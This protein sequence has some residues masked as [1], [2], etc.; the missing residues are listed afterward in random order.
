M[1]AKIKQFS[2]LCIPTRLCLCF[3]RPRYC[4]AYARACAYVLVKA[5]LA[6]HIKSCWNF[7]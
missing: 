6:V 3:G 1:Q 2:I 5:R 7:R 4:Y